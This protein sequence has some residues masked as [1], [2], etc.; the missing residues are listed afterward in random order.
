VPALQAQS[1][2]F[3]LQAYKKTNQP[4]IKTPKLSSLPLPLN[5]AQTAEQMGVRKISQRSV[6]LPG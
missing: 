1:P 6:P 2:E 3:K 4:N 5:S